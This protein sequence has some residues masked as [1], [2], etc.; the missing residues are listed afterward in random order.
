M[1]YRLN[2]NGSQVGPAVN[3]YGYSI[4]LNSS[5]VVQS[6]KL[7][8]NGNV[9]VVA[10]VLS[11]FTAALPEAPIITADPPPLTIVSNGTAASFTVSAIG[12][13]TLTYQ[14]EKNDAALTNGGNVEGATTSELTLTTT[15]TNDDGSYTV[16]VANPYGSVTSSVA[17]LTIGVPPTITNLPTPLIATNGSPALLTV[18]AS[19]TPPLFYQW[20]MDATNLSD[21]GNIAG[22]S[23]AAL[24]LLAA[25]ANDA[26]S[27]DVIVTNAFGS[28][29]S[30]VVTLNV[31]FLLQSVSVAANGSAVNFSWLS[32]PGVAYQVQATTNLATGTWTNLGPAIIA[33][34]S[35]TIDLDTIGPDSQRFYRILQQ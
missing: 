34:N 23:T 17:V 29:T 14:W 26:G 35:V 30:S 11:N 15:S 8:N 24:S 5:L 22:S 2:D 7:P 3:L 9:E 28:V 21:G 18:G 16:I 32:T 1:A 33:T 4:N 25:G 10:I 19:G 27:Y 12:T 6:L 31:V 20:Q 13:A